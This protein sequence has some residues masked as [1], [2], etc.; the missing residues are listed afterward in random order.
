M[1]Q[2]GMKAIEVDLQT[3]HTQ[4]FLSTAWKYQLP[5]GL[6]SFGPTVYVIRNADDTLPRG[7]RLAKTCGLDH[8]GS[9]KF[10]NT[11]ART[12]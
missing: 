8:L 7:I 12:E 11:G 4:N 2:S 9:F 10:N 6:S 3:T 5:A 1:N